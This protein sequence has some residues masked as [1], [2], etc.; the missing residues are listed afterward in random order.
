ML[1]ESYQ[2]MKITYNIILDDA[3]I[4]S[5]LEIESINREKCDKIAQEKLKEFIE[6]LDILEED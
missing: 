5:T 4:L 2:H 1:T 3:R 6:H